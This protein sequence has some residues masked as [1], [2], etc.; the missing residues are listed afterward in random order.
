MKIILDSNI[1]ISFAI[2]KQLLEL[3]YVFNQHDIS[4]YGNLF[5]G[6]N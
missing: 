2:G 5:N 3:E 4:I 6:N 1:W